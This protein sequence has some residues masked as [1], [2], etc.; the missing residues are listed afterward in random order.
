M[1]RARLLIAALTAV[2]ALVVAPAALAAAPA[3]PSISGT[4]GSAIAATTTVATFSDGIDVIG[5]TPV[6]AYTATVNWGD[7]TAVATGAVGFVSGSLT[8]PCLYSVAAGH[9]YAEFGTYAVTVGVSGGGNPGQGVGT[10]TIAD[11]P[12]AAG[13]AVSI[14]GTEQAPVSGTVANFSDANPDA[15]A[16]DYVATVNWGDGSST[17]GT[18]TKQSPGAFSVSASHTYAE[19][20]SY[21]TA[22]TI[23]DK[24]GA[25][26]TVG[27]TATIADAA[28]TAGSAVTITATSGTAFS[29][30][31]GTFTDA[32]T[33]APA[34]D[35]S[36]TITW[37]DGST[38]AATITATSTAGQFGVT[39]SHTYAAAGTFTISVAIRDVG[40]STATLHGS[41]NVAA[42]APPPPPPALT[43][44]QV[45]TPST[46]TGT[47]IHLALAAF[48]DADKGTTASNY[49][50]TIAWGDGATTA[51]TVVATTTAGDFGVVGSHTYTTVGTFT[52]T[53]ALVAPL[54]RTLK[55]TTI[56][57]ISA[58]T[59]TTPPPPPP[60]PAPAK[61]TLAIA[62]KHVAVVRGRGLTAKVS[63]PASASTCRGYVSAK[64]G[65][66][67]LGSSLFILPG[68]KSGTF[69]LRLPASLRRRHARLT[70]NVTASD[71]RSKLTGHAS[72][73]ISA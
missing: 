5:C 6:S 17:A 31:V 32:D 18:V 38:S 13:A 55:I 29:G 30:S 37:G 60:P 61:T 35:F 59:T 1:T 15:S 70:V 54:N 50:A 22:V 20:G 3:V 19:E 28:L 72:K 8:K 53:I 46:T 45:V 48:S 2:L 56:A 33:A 64:A 39:G 73:T 67:G 23:N 41:A 68:G 63:C 36:G 65:G 14:S 9:T 26:I 21:P 69:D 7:G 11:A 66:R 43:T 57:H 27:G 10:A 25:S 51:G 49:S 58:A 52:I 71:P 12:L 44:L 47:P 4:E 42:A 24:G 34:G 16:A 40:G 62:L